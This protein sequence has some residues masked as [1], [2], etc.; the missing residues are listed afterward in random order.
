VRLPLL[1]PF[2]AAHGTEHERT[3]ILVSVRGD[4]DGELGLE[5]WGE[6]STLS[7][8]TY[9]TEHTTGAW[10]RLR[11]DLVPALLAGASGPDDTS[12]DDASADGASP[13]ASAALRG[14]VLDLQLRRRGASLAASTGGR[15]TEVASTAVIGQRSSIDELLAVVASRVEAGHGSVK[16]KVTPD[17][18]LDPL[19]AVRA[20]WPDLHLAADAN[21]SFD[22]GDPDHRGTL[23]GLESLELGY[24]EQPYPAGADAALVDLSRADGPP[25]ALDESLAAVGDLERLVAAGG[26]FVL[27]LKPARV[28]GLDA[29]LAIATCAASEE[30]PV[31][32]G[33]MLETG[34]GRAHA[35]AVASWDACTLPTDL[36]P[37]ANYFAEDLTEPFELLDGGRLAVPSGPGIGVVPDPDRLASAT[38]ERVE[39]RA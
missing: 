31:F 12:A 8:P 2:V 39:L 17:R 4:D 29:A 7:A 30:L 21:G 22:P 37:S 23:A 10:A 28:G 25:I 24:L 20:L 36:G 16:L 5:G 9:T 11:D 18:A 33:G 6:C 32:V 14:A 1:E 26:R 35:L 15:R 34:V 27:N 38:V 13:M 19:A 3:V